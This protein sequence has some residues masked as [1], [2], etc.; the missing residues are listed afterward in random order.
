MAVSRG[1]VGGGSTPIPLETP[2]EQAHHPLLRFP[3]P[4]EADLPPP[5]FPPPLGS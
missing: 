4:W 3:P 5:G 2:E 1:T